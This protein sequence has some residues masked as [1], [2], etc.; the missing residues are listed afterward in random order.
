MKPMKKQMII[1]LSV[2]AVI[3][4]VAGLI[5]GLTTNDKDEDTSPKQESPKIET[6]EIPITPSNPTD[7]EAPEVPNTPDVP[8]VPTYPDTP[9]SSPDAPDA[10]T[11]PDTPAEPDTPVAPTPSTPP[12]PDEPQPDVPPAE[13]S[14]PTTPVEPEVP[15]EPDKPTEPETPEVPITPTVPHTHSYVAKV[16]REAN[17]GQ[18]GKITYTCSC[19]NSYSETTDREPDDHDFDEGKLNGVMMIYTCKRCTKTKKVNVCNH[20]W[21]D[22]KVIRVGSCVDGYSRRVCQN[23]YLEEKETI[24]AVGHCVYEVIDEGK[25]TRTSWCVGCYTTKTEE[26]PDGNPNYVPSPTVPSTPSNIPGTKYW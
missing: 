10:P 22:W 1:I 13:P 21:T 5:I 6:P 16:V 19:G 15:T 20:I 24:P 17:C 7:P 12:T 9:V 14:N 2:L 8:S 18:M 23:C 11:N 26:F 25:T 4:F 3:G